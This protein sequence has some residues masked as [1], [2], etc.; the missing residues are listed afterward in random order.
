VS[1]RVP[2]LALLAALLTGCDAGG[3]LLARGA[4]AEAAGNFAEARAR[5]QEACDK[6]SKHCPLATRL[7]ERLSV[8][9]A[10]KALA[11]GEHDKAKAALDSALGAGDPA[12]KAAAEAASQTEDFARWRSFEEAAALPD[13][14]QALA[15][16]EAIADLG[17]PAAARAREWLEKNRPAVLLGRIR[18]ACKAGASVS[19]A[20]A[21]KALAARHPK[22]PENAEAQ[23]L[24]EADYERVHPLLKQAENLLIQR[25][26]LYDKDIL[27][28]RCIENMGPENVVTCE[29]TVV[30]GRRLPT[31]GFLDGAWKKKMG[32][33]GDPLFVKALEARYARAA[34]SGEYDPE[35]WPKPAGAK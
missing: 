12:V 26:E 23:R 7:R 24:V 6:G 4:D 32:E 29:T 19:C 17:V 15:P 20:E 9:E 18:I 13:K 22:S 2:S 30:G 33:I 25:V 14:D 5:Y 34:S 1:P 3:D 8:K 31:L 16:I 21:G 28:A 11:A 27:V 35:P 10:W